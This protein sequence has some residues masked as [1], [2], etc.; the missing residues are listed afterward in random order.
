MITQV[1]FIKHVVLPIQLWYIKSAQNI[2]WEA[3]LI[4]I[5]MKFKLQHAKAMISL[6]LSHKEKESERL[7]QDEIVLRCKSLTD[8]SLYL[9]IRF[10]IREDAKRIKF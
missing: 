9:K 3:Q 7:N 1:S 6:R 10:P 4:P 8:I 5:Q 2:A